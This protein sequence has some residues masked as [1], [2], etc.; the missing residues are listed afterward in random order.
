MPSKTAKN[1]YLFIACLDWIIGFFQQTVVRF[2]Y[3]LIWNSIAFSFF[4]LYHQQGKMSKYTVTC[5]FLYRFFGSKLSQIKKFKDI[6]HF[7]FFKETRI[8]DYKQPKYLRRMQIERF[9]IMD[10]ISEMWDLMQIQGKLGNINSALFCSVIFFSTI[11]NTFKINP[12]K[13]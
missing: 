3:I 9:R 4:F 10:A 12:K 1:C 6:N 11:L 2:Y 5:P 7:Y 8:K 13:F